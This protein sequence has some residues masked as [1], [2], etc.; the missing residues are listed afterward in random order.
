MMKLI[1]KIS[2][3][4][5][6]VLC[7]NLT[8]GQTLSLSEAINIGL[9]N[10][11]KIK[12]FYERF[13]QKKF[14]DLSSYGNFLPSIMLEGNFTHLNQELNIDLNPI[15]EVI[16]NL[17][18]K[19]QVEL[20]NI[21]NILNNGNPLP[22]EI[23][24]NIFSQTLSTLN[25]TIPSFE[26]TFKKQNY[27]T[28]TLFITQPL[29]LGGKLIAAKNYATAEKKS[30]EIE[31]TKV[32]NEI[33]SEIIVNYLRVLLLNNVVK[34][35][36][37]VLN[38]MRNH[39]KEAKKLYDEGL[40]AVNNYL[41]AK[42]AVAE[43]ENNL[44]TDKNNLELS[45]IILKKSLGIDQNTSFVLTDS[46]V[47]KEIKDSVNVFK[48]NAFESQPLLKIIQEKNIEANQN[49]SIARSEFLPKI[50]AFGKYEMYPQYLSSLEPRW[51]VGIQF[52]LNIFKGFK[53]YLN[54]QS[55]KHLENE[56]K[57]LESDVR[58][59][60]S[61]WIDKSYKDMQNAKTRYEKLS[62]TESLALENLKQNEKRFEAGMATSLE[63]IDAQLSLEKVKVD[64]LKSLFDYYETLS[65]LFLAEG[66]PNKF[67]R[68]WY[69]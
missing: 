6:I 5:I 58:K 7:N 18:A 16:T 44:S 4:L 41:R 19:N 15:K 40:I 3:F 30:A 34:T 25:S 62:V 24:N 48:Q 37:E 55:A 27:W 26:E 67:L 50:V 43:A 53:D 63:V 57:F 17:Q 8:F 13:A 49:F 20:A 10:N 39:E 32:K 68:I 56:L 21:Y 33:E 1:K 36:E 65:S 31:L 9:K 69:E 22:I 46:L 47:F 23:K 66:N 38:G 60:V 35:R 42:V 2:P 64:R 28:A 29:F 59:Q 61:L 52:N 11:D 12:Q 54:L 45:W 14:D 51:A